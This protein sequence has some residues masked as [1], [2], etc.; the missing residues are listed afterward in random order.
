MTEPH[1]LPPEMQAAIDRAQARVE[2]SALRLTRTY[3]DEEFT[4]LFLPT[5]NQDAL[6]I[7]TTVQRLSSNSEPDLTAQLD[8]LLDFM[9]VMA[10]QDTSALIAQLGRA[11]IMTINDLV[12][13]QMAVVGSVAGRP[14]TRSSSAPTGSSPSGESSTAGAPTEDSTQQ[15][16][17]STG[18]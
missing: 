18:S 5:L 17:L 13:L 1:K 6:S 4:F 16:S 9:D 7:V 3:F 2:A 8:A 11:G 14:T 15:P 12:D 10:M